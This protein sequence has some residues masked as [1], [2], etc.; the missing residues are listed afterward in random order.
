MAVIITI[1]GVLCLVSLAV[2]LT[3]RSR[4]A[5]SPARIPLCPPVTLARR[6]GPVARVL[7]RPDRPV[8]T[9]AVWLMLWD[10][11]LALAAPWPLMLVVDYGLGHRPYPSWAAGMGSFSAAGLA[12]AA[13][14]AGLLLLALGAVAGYLVTFLTGVVGE[15]VTARLRA[16]LVAHVLRIAPRDAAQY[17]TGELLNRVSA[18]TARVSD[19][20]VAIADTLLPDSV[21]L[22]GMIVITAL[23]DWRLT[24]V[25]LGVVP[26]YA[27]TARR[28]NR[29]LHGAQRRARERAG[30]LSALTA[31]L[32]ARIPAVHVFGRADG[33]AERYHRVSTQSA[34]AEVAAL[35]A[36]ARFGPVADM[37]PGLGLAGALV[38]GT[39]EVSAGRLTP[40]RLA[41]VPRLPVQPD[42]TGPV[43]GP[44]QHDDH[45]W[46]REPG[47]DR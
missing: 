16:G 22:A 2:G 18:D 43:A 6:W 39:L 9:L 13:A 3:V 25:V 38:A 47:Q 7:L 42:R 23:L 41:G 32:L 19:T 28:R 45:A 37:L 34:G 46:L 11:V 31:D 35:D 29:A 14:G 24:L 40:R 5:P 20:V 17:A 4:L 33:E 10:A 8:I 26:L 27:L 1:A 36:S 15:R 12:A 30:E 21:L 44:A